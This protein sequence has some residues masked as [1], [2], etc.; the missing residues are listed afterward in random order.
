VPDAIA[1]DGSEIYFRVADAERASLV[2]VVLQP[3]R[4]S[5][6]IR[7]RTVEEIWHFMAGAGNVWLRSPDGAVDSIR[8]VETGVTVTIPTGWAFQ[9]QA[10]GSEPLR[11]LCFTSPPWPG[12]DEAVPVPQGGLG[13]ANL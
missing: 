10:T 8:N 4:T 12:D 13:A 2:E 7:H 9:F 1:P 5:R 3:G 11:F 6:P